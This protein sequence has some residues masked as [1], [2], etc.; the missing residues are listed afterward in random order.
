MQT[1]ETIV[2]LSDEYNEKEQIRVIKRVSDEDPSQVEYAILLEIDEY[3]EEIPEG[4]YPEEWGPGPEY[5]F[6]GVTLE[7]EQFEALKKAL[8]EM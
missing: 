1:T 6:P 5:L 8:N 7:P 3:S 2:K 4:C